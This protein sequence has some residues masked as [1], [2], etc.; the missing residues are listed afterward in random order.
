MNRKVE[1]SERS[2]AFAILFPLGLAFLWLIH[3]IL[4]SL[5][6]AF[7]LSSALR[8]V[9]D[10]LADRRV[11]R[12]PSTF[13]VF[14]GFILIVVGLVYLIIP[15][16]VSET[17]TFVRNFPTIVQSINPEVRKYIDFNSI[18]QYLPNVTNNL[19]GIISNVF[20]NVFFVI[21]TMFFALYFLMEKNVLE[22]LLHPYFSKSQIEHM[23]RAALNVEA[24]LTSWFW[25][26]ITLMTV[27]GVVTYI[28]LFFAGIRYALPLAVLAGLLEIVPNL[29]P[30]LSAIPAI[31]IG[32]A[33]SPVLG[34]S[35]A[36]IYIII[37]QLENAVIVPIIMK[38]AVG[39]S[40]IMTLLSLL[41][42]A[43]IG[44]VLGVLLSIPI[45]IIGQAV[46]TEVMAYYNG[47]NK[48]QAIQNSQDA[49]KD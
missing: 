21:T 8:P 38:R 41:I 49:R 43:K 25:G 22:R 27:I 32:L 36:A 17:T 1:I 2:I 10:Y 12:G 5:L 9:V 44:G 30:I 31:T 28:C 29:G 45:L 26:Q 39:L 42:G 18:S 34:L 47:K 11:P 33:E 19:F 14:F 6:I 48:K 23:K 37:Q 35:I 46:V 15:P 24:R 4:F 7:I 20:S 40:P 16:I 13:L 3:D